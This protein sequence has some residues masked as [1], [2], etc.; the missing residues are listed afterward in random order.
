[1]TQPGQL[2]HTGSFL[3]IYCHDNKPGGGGWE[4]PHLRDSE[5]AHQGKESDPSIPQ[6]PL[7]GTTSFTDNSSSEMVGL[8]FLILTGV[9]KSLL[10]EGEELL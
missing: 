10:R 4:S 1:M 7:L 6:I 5:I 9:E 2:T 3:T 8:W